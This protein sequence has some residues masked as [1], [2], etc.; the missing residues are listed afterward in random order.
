MIPMHVM[1]SIS[2]EVVKLRVQNCKG[3]VVK[4]QK[5]VC[6]DRELA[7]SNSFVQDYGVSD[8]NVFHMVLK[9]FDL[10]IIYVRIAYGEEFTFHV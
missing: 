7:K 2:I 5:L 9:L 8:E 4:K 3:F 1:G 10:Q 6:G